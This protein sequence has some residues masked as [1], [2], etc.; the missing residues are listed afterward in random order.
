[1]DKVRVSAGSQLCE[2]PQGLKSSQVHVSMSFSHPLYVCVSASYTE[3]GSH[4]DEPCPSVCKRL[5]GES[6]VKHGPLSRMN[7]M[8]NMPK[9]NPYV[10]EFRVSVLVM[11]VII[12]LSCDGSYTHTLEPIAHRMPMRLE[13][14]CVWIYEYYREYA[15]L[16]TFCDFT[17][18]SN[19]AG[20]FQFR[21]WLNL[22]HRTFAL[23]SGGT[24]QRVAPIGGGIDHDCVS[25]RDWRTP[26]RIPC[27]E[28]LLQPVLHRSIQLQ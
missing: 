7:V 27:G 1:M 11:H 10:G 22:D 15:L 9:H 28:E 23:E 21:E 13:I 6:I 20:V 8:V 25:K 17:M 16:D 18:Q 19:D 5:E 24:D 3:P 4:L 12:S 2:L 26:T 14:P